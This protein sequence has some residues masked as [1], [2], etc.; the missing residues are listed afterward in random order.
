MRDV[1]F[2]IIEKIFSYMNI[3]FFKRNGNNFNLISLCSFLINSTSVAL[4]LNDIGNILFNYITSSVFF[5]L[6]PSINSYIPNYSFSITC[7]NKVIVFI[8]YQNIQLSIK[9]NIK[10]AEIFKKKMEP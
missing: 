1:N 6:P 7:K 2:F 3:L 9:Y 5:S 4:D 10:L 8:N